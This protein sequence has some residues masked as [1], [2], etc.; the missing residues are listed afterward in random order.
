MKQE[1]TTQQQHIA[2]NHV[3]QSIVDPDMKAILDLTDC[4]NN[5]IIIK[6]RITSLKPR[7]VDNTKYIAIDI[8]TF[9]HKGNHVAYAVGIHGK[10][11]RSQKLLHLSDYITEYIDPQSKSDLAG[12]SN[13][14]INDIIDFMLNSYKCKLHIFA[15][16]L[17]S[18]DGYFILKCLIEKVEDLKE[19]KYIIDDTDQI[20]EL[21]YKNLTFRDSYRIFP[22]SLKKLGEICKL[23]Q[24]KLPFDHEHVNY[25]DLINIQH[26]D[27]VLKYLYNDVLMLYE[28]IQK[29]QENI[30]SD[31]SIP[32]NKIYS[33][34]NLAFTVFRTKFLS[35]DRNIHSCTLH[36]YNLIKPTYF[37][38]AVEVYINSGED[39]YYYDVNSLYPYAMLNPLPTRY[40]STVRPSLGEFIYEDMFGFVD[41]EIS[42]PKCTKNP[43]VPVRLDEGII[44]PTGVIKGR[45]FSEEVKAWIKI[46]YNV[47]ITQVY[48]F[49]KEYDLF[50][51]YVKHFYGL[52]A[53][54][55][56]E[57]KRFLNKL[58]LNGLYGYFGRKVVYS[59]TKIIKKWELDTEKDVINHIDLNETTIYVEYSN[60]S[61]KIRGEEG[62]DP[63]HIWEVINDSTD[64]LNLSNISISSAITSYARIH[65]Q[66]YKLIPDNKIFYSD[67]DSIV[68]QKPLQ[69]G[70]SNEIGDL[71]LEYKIK[72]AIFIRPKLYGIIT[73]SDK[74]IIKCAGYPKDSIN[75]KDLRE[76]YNDP[77]Y[78]KEVKS[79]TMFKNMEGLNITSKDV[80]KKLRNVDPI[81]IKRPHVNMNTK[82]LHL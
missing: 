62:Y 81:T 25:E 44:Y 16:N 61:E 46:G 7:Y 9:K 12:I 1:N 74:E 31:Y 63:E 54:K 57:D 35:N 67:T 70:I 38:G 11:K 71:K 8:E 64:Y 5:S 56:H 73:D 15:H 82:P 65:M 3:T 23:Y 36:E 78:T 4:L 20:I 29:F 53:D 79:F 32:L 39:L 68:L 77:K 14:M 28:I 34:S 55:T 24:T 66:K 18:F 22:A 72:E 17:G 42:I 51:D 48:K 26:K 37:G 69:T 60:K 49:T 76:L 6:E 33:T 30:L 13:K 19:I 21:K 75:Y 40:I 41:C 80:Y 43:Q 45:Y 2:N 58:M 59:D 52:K 50:K 27:K 47:E 10:S